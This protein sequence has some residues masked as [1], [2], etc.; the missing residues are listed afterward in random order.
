MHGY[1]TRVGN[2]ATAGA[3]VFP[4]CRRAGSTAWLPV[5]AEGRRRS[6]T[7]APVQE[8]C[9]HAPFTFSIPNSA[10]PLHALH[11]RIPPH[12][13]PFPCRLCSRTSFAF[14]AVGLSNIV[15]SPFP[16]A[17]PSTPPCCLFIGCLQDQL[18]LH[19]RASVQHRPLP[20]PLPVPQPLLVVSLRRLLPRS[21]PPSPP[22]V[23]PT[24]ST[25]PV[26][27][28]ASAT[29]AQTRSACPSLSR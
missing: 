26:P 2:G 14:T 4:R 25:Q 24:S 1:W 10:R 20:L 8:L 5:D 23:C 21:A 28:W 9:L 15:D 17:P 27:L 19:C 7:V 29:H 6:T 22:W 11:S 16:T 3:M 12:S 13:S 18:R